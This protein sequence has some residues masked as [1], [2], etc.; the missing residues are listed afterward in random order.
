MKVS[1]YHLALTYRH[2]QNLNSHGK[3]QAIVTQ[4]CS[5]SLFRFDLV[6]RGFQIELARPNSETCKMS[7]NTD[8]WVKESEQEQPAH[9]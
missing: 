6:R 9:T 2:T 4:V 8:K 5:F 7:W 1:L 3:T